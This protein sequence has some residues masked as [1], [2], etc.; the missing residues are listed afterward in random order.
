[1]ETQSYFNVYSGCIRAVDADVRYAFN[2]RLGCLHHCLHM[3][4]RSNINHSFHFL[5]V[6]LLYEY[7]SVSEF[8]SKHI[9]Q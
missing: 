2:C 4:L 7:N 3:K 9:I 1:M 5:H 8:S 6:I